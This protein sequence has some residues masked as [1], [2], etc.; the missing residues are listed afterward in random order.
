MGHPMG[1]PE[2]SRGGA[3]ISRQM[4]VLSRN[5]DKALHAATW[6][7]A[8][9]LPILKISIKP[10]GAVITVACRPILF[11]L[12]ARDCAWRQRR[13]VGAAIVYTWF[14]VRYG[15]RIEWEEIECRA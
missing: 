9:N 4:Q 1:H 10:T 14:A 2:F 13:K 7:C 6:L 8:L 5:M 15:A 3:M 11:R 12:F